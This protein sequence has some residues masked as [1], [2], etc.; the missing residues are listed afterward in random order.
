MLQFM[1]SFDSLAIHQ[2]QIS[3]NNAESVA[4]DSIISNLISS[5]CSAS[6]VSLIQQEK[7]M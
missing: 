6:K 4:V 2:Y 5:E 7:E 3:N 1:K